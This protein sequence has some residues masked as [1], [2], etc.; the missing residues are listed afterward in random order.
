M[1]DHATAALALPGDFEPCKR[2]KG[3]IEGVYPS[4]L[5][6]GVY[7]RPGDNAPCFMYLRCWPDGRVEFLE[8]QYSQRAKELL[9]GGK[10]VAD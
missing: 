8:K 9:T 4:T 3:R 5:L 7:R 1:N 10:H 2:D 6:L